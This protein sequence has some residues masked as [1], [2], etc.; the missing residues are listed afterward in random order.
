MTLEKLL[1]KRFARYSDKELIDRCNK[2]YYNGKNTDDIEYEI[3]RRIR[4]KGIIVKPE[5]DKYVLIKEVV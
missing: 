2:D 4:D 5:Y 1:K 3:S